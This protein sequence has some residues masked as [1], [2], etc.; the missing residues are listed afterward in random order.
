MGIGTQPPTG[1][2]YYQ[3]TTWD[4]G[5]GVRANYFSKVFYQNFGFVHSFSGASSLGNFPP[6]HRQLREDSQQI[7]RLYRLLAVAVR[8]SWKEL[9]RK[10][11]LA[12]VWDTMQTI[13]ALIGEPALPGH[14][15]GRWWS[16]REQE[17]LLFATPFEPSGPFEDVPRR[18]VSMRDTLL[19][20]INATNGAGYPNPS[21]PGTTSWRSLTTTAM[22]RTEAPLHGR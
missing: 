15:R 21:P 19:L 11:G 8:G 22:L 7:F 14:N 9:Y 3:F 4:R 6:I 5:I 2:G 20:L 1:I 12:D 13:L 10:T 18:S 16:L 17:W